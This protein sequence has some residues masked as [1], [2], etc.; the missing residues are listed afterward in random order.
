MD[1]IEYTPEELAQAQRIVAAE[2]ARQAAL[3]QARAEAYAVPV[4]ELVTGTAW[5]DVL[6]GLTDIHQT[7][8]PDN[9]MSVHVSALCEIMSR[10]AGQI[11]AD[12]N[13]QPVA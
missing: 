13:T 6:A 8:E 5:S 4:R 10:L 7:Y 12:P 3:A 11:P 9:I 1:D 2:Q